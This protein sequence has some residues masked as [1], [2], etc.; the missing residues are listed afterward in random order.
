MCAIVVG[1]Y[2]GCA[3]KSGIESGIGFCKTGHPMPLTDIAIRKAKPKAK[4]YKLADAGGLHLFV[5]TAGAKLWRWRYEFD[6]RE[7]TLGLGPYPELSLADARSARDDARKILRQGR[8]PNAVKRAVKAQTKRESG[9]TFEVVAREWHAI[10]VPGWSQAYAKDVMERLERHVFPKIGTIPVR[11]VA[12]SDVRSFVSDLEKRAIPTARLMRERTSAVF[13]YAIATERCANNPAAPLKRYT[14]Q[15]T[16]RKQP[17][18]VDLTEARE[19][20]HATDATQSRTTTKLAMR[21]LALTAVR[22]SVILR[23]PWAEFDTVDPERP[24]WTVPAARMKLILRLKADPGR[25]HL[26]P[27]SKQAVETIAELRKITG[28]RH[29]L[30]PGIPNWK[31]HAGETRFREMLQDAGYEGRHVPHGWRSTF[32]TI[33]NERFRADRAVIDF[34]LAH[35]PKDKTEAAYN[36]ADYIDRRIE[37]AQIWADLLTAGLPPAAKIAALRD[38]EV[39]PQSEPSP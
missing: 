36:R 39:T 21:L 15:A 3:R 27:L 26:V 23:A 20:L 5:S 14:A 37:L 13:D 19:I 38:F 30:L 24:I 12:V 29:W 18:I 16:T 4:S 7:Q 10:M 8:D 25:D 34:M 17:A 22:P 32:S 2:V 1:R 33:M 6:K 11:D 9:E 31:V 28:A 35:V